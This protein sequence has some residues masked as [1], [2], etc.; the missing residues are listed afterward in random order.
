MLNKVAPALLNNYTKVFVL[1]IYAA[2]T[3]FSVDACFD[4]E[5][6]YSQ[7]MM[8]NEEFYSYDSLQA[9]KRYWDNTYNPITFMYLND[10]VDFF[11]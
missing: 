10:T 2:F 5:T 6:Y 8:V 9:R 3:I 7:E 11:S 1:L 4:L